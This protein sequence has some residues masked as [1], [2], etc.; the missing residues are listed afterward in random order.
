MLL[1]PIA[2]S[3]AREGRS[4]QKAPETSLEIVNFRKHLCTVSGYK[5]GHES[6]EI[7][8]RTPH[9]DPRDIRWDIQSLD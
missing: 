2:I 1:D 5:T 4:D 6:D 7:K 8:N 9:N 3:F